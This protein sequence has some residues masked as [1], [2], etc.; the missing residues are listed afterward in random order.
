MCTQD[1]VR[2]YFT[3]L[4]MQLMNK[5]AHQAFAGRRSTAS[6][7][8]MRDIKDAVERVRSTA[9][10]TMM[11]ISSLR[12]FTRHNIHCVCVATCHAGK[13]PSDVA[14]GEPRTC[15]ITGQQLDA[16]CAIVTKRCKACDNLNGFRGLPPTC[17][18]REDKTVTVYCA[19][20]Y[21]DF[22]RMVWFV[23][24]FRSLTAEYVSH[25]LARA[26]RLVAKCTGPDACRALARR[27]MAS[28]G[29][30]QDDVVARTHAALTG[31]LVHVGAS[32]KLYIEMCSKEREGGRI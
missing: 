24:H 1:D 17:Q 26:P 4:A 16:A 23:S 10:G 30:A 3:I 22:A 7:H 20:R 32:V 9:K 8:E 13:M 12:N 29:V 14:L 28:R 18:T 19:R 15:A 11:H 5:E 27:L 25:K 21:V 2:E 6:L 31:A